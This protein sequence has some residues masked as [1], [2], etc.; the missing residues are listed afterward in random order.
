[1]RLANNLSKVT[2][3]RG[4]EAVTGRMGLAWMVD[5]LRH[6]GLNEMVSDGYRQEK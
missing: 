6:F 1:M 4:K 2:L 5:G 3:K